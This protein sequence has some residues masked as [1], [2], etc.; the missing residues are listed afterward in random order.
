MITNTIFYFL[1]TSKNKKIFSDF[2]FFFREDDN[3]Y[4]G[5]IYR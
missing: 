4:D 1:R 3:L 2:I 5:N